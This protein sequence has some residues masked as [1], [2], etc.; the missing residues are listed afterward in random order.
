MATMDVFEVE[1]CGV[2]SASHHFFMQKWTPFIRENYTI[3][4]KKQMS[5]ILMLSVVIVRRIAECTEN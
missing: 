2:W 1:F 3:K 4:E 5:K